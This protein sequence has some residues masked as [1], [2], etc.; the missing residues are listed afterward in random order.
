MFLYGDPSLGKTYAAYHFGRGDEEIYAIT[1]TEDTPAAE[2]RGHYVPVEGELVWQ[3]GPFTAAM[4]SGAR[5]VI[6]E[7]THGPPEAQSLLYPVL[8]SM[9]TARITLPTNETVR[10]APGFQVICTDNLAPEELP[11]A[12]QD[13]FDSII[14]VTEPHPKAFDKLPDDLRQAARRSFALEPNRR[15]SIR[16]WLA[17]DRLRGKVGLQNALRA[18]LGMERGDQVMDALNLGKA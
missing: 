5:L 17:I 8:E 1:L 3:D 16:R 12:L 18:V 9:E 6:N 14:E 15:I 10:P 11:E 13:R 2:L 7:V 4:R